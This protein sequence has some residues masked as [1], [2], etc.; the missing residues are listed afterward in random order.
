MKCDVCK[1][2][3]Y[4]KLDHHNLKI[5]E[6]CFIK[7]FKKKVEKTIRKLK[8][9]NIGEKLLLAVSG[10]KDSM[11]LWYLLTDLGFEVDGVHIDL[12]LGEIS[13]KSKEITENFSKDIKKKLYKI[14]LKERTGFNLSE[15]SKFTKRV[16]C[17]L[18]GL[19]KRYLMNEIALKENYS[20][21]LTGH[22]LDDETSTLLSNVLRWELSYLGR[23]APLLEEMNGFAKK[24]KPYIFCYEKETLLYAKILKIPFLEENCPYSIKAKNK[25]LKASLNI[26]EDS[27]PG[28]KLNFIKLFLK[29]RNFFLPFREIELKNLVKRCKN[30][31]Y[32]T[33]R[34]VCALCTIIERGKNENSTCK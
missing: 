29:N 32:P 31:G 17:S 22:N 18:C 10:G 6:L 8:L 12:G 34:E 2:E 5:C 25:N 23:Q 16:P 4:I 27:S 33:E 19:L 21:I 14:E 11:G 24:A 1:K 28:T 20:A 26:L 3:A 13:Y 30:C 9:F 7:F 15:L